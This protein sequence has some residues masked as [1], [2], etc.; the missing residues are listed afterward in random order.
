MSKAAEVIKRLGGVEV[1]RNRAPFYYSKVERLAARARI[2]MPKLYVM[3]DS[4]PNAC[5]V[6][7]S[8][9]DTA[10]GVTTGL[11]SNMDENEIEAVLAH[12]IGHIQKGHSI[13]KTKVAMKA[14]VISATAGLGGHAIATSDLDFTPGDD[15]SD[16]LLSTVFKIGLGVAAATAGNA[17][18]SSVLS[19]ASF[20]S[21]FEADQMGGVLS[22][23]PWALASALKRIQDLTQVGE[24]K[25]AP[26]VSQL[27]IMSPAYLNYNTHPPTSERIKRLLGLNVKQPEMIHLATI[28]CSTCGEKTDADGH[29]CYWCGCDLTM[30]FG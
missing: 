4:A 27:F 18:A 6:G 8:I 7:L 12:E 19:S 23:K 29:F 17:V 30:N 5:A 2:K 28:F 14:L 10:V 11:L 22:G 1:S 20:R 13:E 26:E 21:E 16:D 15:D 24:K 9:D 25:L 3:P